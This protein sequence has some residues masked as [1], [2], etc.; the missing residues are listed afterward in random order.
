VNPEISKMRILPIVLLILV[1]GCT[2]VP[3][4]PVQTPQKP[5][6]P[7]A[8]GVTRVISK[9][10]AA[11]GEPVK[12]TLYTNV[13]DGQAYYLI[14]ENVSKSLA[15]SGQEINRNNQIMI[16]KLSDVKSTVY[17]YTVTASAAGT[18]Q[19]SGIYALDQSPKPIMGDSTLQVR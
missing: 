12:I 18:Y 1:L 5:V 19:M 2:Q 7:T 16:A 10:E 9:A 14:E 3:V 15:V 17:E 8:M 13:P 6:V 11:V 4:Q